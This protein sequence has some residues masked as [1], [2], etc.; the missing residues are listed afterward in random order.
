MKL[1]KLVFL[2]AV[3]NHSLT[4]KAVVNLFED[5]V[6]W[7]ISDSLIY[8]P[9]Y[10]EYCHWDQEK[11]WGKRQDFSTFEDTLKLTLVEDKC[12]FS[13]PFIGRITSDY[14]WRNHRPHYGVDLKLQMGDSVRA[15]FEGVVR[16]AKYSSSYGN[17]VVVRHQNGLE[18]LYAH[19]SRIL[20]AEGE[21]IDVGSL[22]GWGGSSGRSTGSHLHFEVRYLGEALDPSTLFEIDDHQFDL[23]SEVALLTNEAFN[24]AI[25]ARKHRFH[26]VRRGESLWVLSRKYN[27]SVRKLCALNGISRKSTLKIGQS[28]RYR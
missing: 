28:I 24:L 21:V 4:V 5:S 27:I 7:D 14:G 1:A 20:V 12:Q 3:L 18:T 23:K 11:I 9:A 15:I 19:L 16:I 17:V 26:Q 10:D 6:E 25:Q 13:S 22:V 8:L 2:L